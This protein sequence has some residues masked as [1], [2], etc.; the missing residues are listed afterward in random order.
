MT[1]T[2][3][4]K[5]SAIQSIGLVISKKYASFRESF[6]DASDN[7]QRVTFEQFKRF[8]EKYHALN[9][10]NMTLPLLQKLFAELDPHKKGFL[11]ESDWSNSL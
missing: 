9:G 2:F 11:T 8:V 6:D 10:F 4:W 5:L 7:S 3:D 1:S